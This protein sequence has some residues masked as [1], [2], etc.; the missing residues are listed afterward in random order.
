MQ[1]SVF[2]NLTVEGFH[3]W[4]EAPEF[5]ATSAVGF[6]KYRHRHVFHIHAEKVIDSDRQ[7]EFI[8]LKREIGDYL[9]SH[10]GNGG[11][12]LE[13]GTMSCE[14]IAIELSDAFELSVC[15]VSEDGENGS[16]VTT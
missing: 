1:V 14:A 8:I 6:L 5:P 9:R 11:N 15:S 3:C 4:P 10:Y 12:V 16:V 2:C 13:F 7:V